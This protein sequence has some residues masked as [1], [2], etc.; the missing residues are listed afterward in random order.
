MI[1]AL[2][3]V[4]LPGTSGFVGEFMIIIGTFK[5][6]FW[7]SFTAALT[8]IVAASYTL[9]MYKRV[10][11]GQLNPAVTVELQDIN[12]LEKLVM[13]LLVI[14][15]FAIGIYPNFLLTPMHASIDNLLALALKSKLLV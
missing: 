3:N 9:W 11:Y 13:W 14:A 2:A 10:F 5:A 1:F 4:G 12:T 6:N 15:I 8:L 7:I